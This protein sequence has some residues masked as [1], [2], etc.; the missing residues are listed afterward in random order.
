MAIYVLFPII[1]I[2][3][4]EGLGQ[5]TMALFSAK[6]TAHFERSERQQMAMWLAPGIPRIAAAAFL[7]PRSEKIRKLYGEF[8]DHLWIWTLSAFIIGLVI[9]WGY[10]RHDQGRP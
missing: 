2:A 7:V 3:A 4:V 6:A 9:A 8:L 1:I 5:L 10:F